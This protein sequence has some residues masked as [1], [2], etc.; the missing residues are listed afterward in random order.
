MV[1]E[2]IAIFQKLSDEAIVLLSS[3]VLSNWH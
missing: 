1:F 3:V 2:Y